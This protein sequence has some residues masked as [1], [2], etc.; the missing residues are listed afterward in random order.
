MKKPNLERLAQKVILW[1]PV[2]FWI[3]KV[4]N[5]ATELLSKVVNYGSPIPKLRSFI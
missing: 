2:V 5:E 1:G 3:L 4:A